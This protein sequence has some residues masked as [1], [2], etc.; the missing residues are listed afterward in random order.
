VV[1]A[2]QVYEGDGRSEHDRIA[3]ALLDAEKRAKDELLAATRPRTLQMKFTA[4][5]MTDLKQEFGL[6]LSKKLIDDMV[7]DNILLMQHKQHKKL[8]RIFG[9]PKEMME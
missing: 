1:E 6:D 9:L 2:I 8:E 7:V 3:Q 5:A 4:E